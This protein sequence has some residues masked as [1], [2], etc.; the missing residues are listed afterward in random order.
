MNKKLCNSML[1]KKNF[2]LVTET[3][4]SSG[5]MSS[6]RGLREKEREVLNEWLVENKIVL[7]ARTRREFSDVL[8]VAKILKNKYGRLV[9]LQY[10]VPRS[11]QALKLVN[12]IVFNEKVLK[13]LNVNLSRETMEDLARGSAWA[14]DSLLYFVATGKNPGLGRFVSKPRSYSMPRRQLIRSDPDCA[15]HPCLFINKNSFKNGF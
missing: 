3:S 10:Y 7:D 12:W 4:Q 11:S 5:I 9:Q 2:D 13:C 1:F 8:P 6:I 14:L 15:S